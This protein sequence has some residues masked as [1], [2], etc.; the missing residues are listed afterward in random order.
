MKYICRS[1]LRLLNRLSGWQPAL[2]RW[3]ASWRRP[4][5]WH[6]EAAEDLEPVAPFGRAAHQR[7]CFGQRIV[8][9][10]SGRPVWCGHARF[11]PRCAR[12]GVTW[13]RRN[14]I[15]VT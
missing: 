9:G 5:P 4:L 11:A 6:A 3:S 8:R 7:Q 13:R 12:A 10:A 14:S 15:M 2:S 1:P